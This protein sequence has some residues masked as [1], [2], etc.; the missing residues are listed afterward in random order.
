ME[1]KE[2]ENRLDSFDKDVRLETL[3]LLREKVDTCKLAHPEKTDFINLHCHSFFSFNAYGYS[4]AHIVWRAFKEGLAVVGIVDFDILDGVE[5]MLE[6]GRILNMKVVAGIET[7]V[8]IKEYSD[9]V[10]NSPREPGVYYLMGTGFYKKP[11]PGSTSDDTIIKLGAITRR[12]NLMILERINNFLNE[13]QI[14]Y[15]HDVLPLTPGGN[16][17]ERHILVVL[18]KKARDVFNNAREKLISFWAE[19]LQINRDKISSVLDS[20]PELQELLR[21]KLMKYGTIGYVL[22]EK[23]SFPTLE[24]VID[25]IEDSDALPVA[26][27]LDGTNEGEREIEQLLKFLIVKG[28]LLLNI[29]PDRN[30]NIKDEEEKKAKVRNLDQVI[31]TANELDL[32]IIVGT[33]M[34]KMGQKFVDDFTVPELSSYLDYF[35]KGALFVYGHTQLARFFNKGYNSCWAKENLAGHTERNSFY[36]KIGEVMQ[37]DYDYENLKRM[38]EDNISPDEILHLL[39]RTTLL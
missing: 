25:M 20:P 12:R 21:L 10:I 11:V 26:T 8:F 28:I 13:L 4:P 30:W 9:K 16:A 14:D 7:R 19:K 6:A 31:K 36:I 34:N 33:E 2:L 15:K 23:G 24:E 37:P 35:R 17:T 3:H 1:I 5:E 27:W 29:I 39:G 22:P 18:E 32:P 38:K